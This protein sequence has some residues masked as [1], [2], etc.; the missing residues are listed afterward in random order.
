MT[1]GYKELSSWTRSQSTSRPSPRA[2]SLSG[3]TSC[4][5]TQIDPNPIS[6]HGD[7]GSQKVTSGADS[8]KT[9]SLLKTF[10]RPT[11]LDRRAVS[12]SLLVSLVSVSIS[13][14]GTRRGLAG[15]EVLGLRT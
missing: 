10:E 12:P 13:N 14:L 9:L 7:L 11:R 1:K 8:D 5:A 15:L 3:K 4:Q 6:S 2:Q